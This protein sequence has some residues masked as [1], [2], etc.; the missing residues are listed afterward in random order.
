[1]PER[2]TS[3]FSLEVIE[4]KSTCDHKEPWQKALLGCS[5]SRE[6]EGPARTQGVRSV[7]PAPVDPSPFST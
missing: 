4:T 5:D 1:M 2:Y 7:V 3:N 6:Q